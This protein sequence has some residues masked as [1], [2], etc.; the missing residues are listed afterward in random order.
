M[1]TEQ[2]LLA[3]IGTLTA[4]VSYLWRKAESRHAALQARYDSLCDYLIE[5]HGVN[6]GVKDSGR[7][8]M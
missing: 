2:M 3:A 7:R 6:D 5:S 1:T 4:A 8:T